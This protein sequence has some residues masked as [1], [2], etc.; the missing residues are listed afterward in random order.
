[1]PR[2]YKLR[3]T[4]TFEETTENGLTLKLRYSMPFDDYVKH[5]AFKQMRSFAKGEFQTSMQ[6]FEAV[7]SIFGGALLVGQTRN[8]F[9]DLSPFE[10]V[11][12][13]Q[14][15]GRDPDRITVFVN[16]EWVT[17][18]KPDHVERTMWEIAADNVAKTE[19]VAFGCAHDD[20]DAV[21]KVQSRLNA[22]LDQAK[23]LAAPYEAEIRKNYRD[24]KRAPQTADDKA[25]MDEI[26]Q[27]WRET[28]PHW[29]WE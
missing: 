25:M 15:S 18:S 26:A 22:V 4:A 1:M 11:D 13:R 23:R 27:T 24:G 2:D 5:G 9:L 10:V 12:Q 29:E 6:D 20:R 21:Y 3:S 17:G 8:G 14:W 7:F 19:R 28:R 16:K